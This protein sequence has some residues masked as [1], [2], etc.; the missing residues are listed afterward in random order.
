VVPWQ[1]YFMEGQ[2][3]LTFIDDFFMKSFIY[4]MNIKFG[5]L[6]LKDFKFLLVQIGKKINMISYDGGGKYNSRIFNVI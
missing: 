5:V 2:K 6:E 1:E 3:N 4:T